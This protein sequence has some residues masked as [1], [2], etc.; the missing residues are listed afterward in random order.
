MIWLRMGVSEGLKEGCNKRDFQRM[1]E[2]ILGMGGLGNYK[3][4]PEIF[5]WSSMRNEI[6]QTSHL[7][8]LT[9]TIRLDVSALFEGPRRL[10]L[11][12][13][14]LFYWMHETSVLSSVPLWIFCASTWA[15]MKYNDYFKISKTRM[16]ECVQNAICISL[17]PISY[18]SLF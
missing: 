3:K 4:W 7:E 9:T 8:Q 10:S 1:N 12:V 16:N 13:R 14:N 17:H 18:M 15:S 5:D 6:P 2:W 11:L